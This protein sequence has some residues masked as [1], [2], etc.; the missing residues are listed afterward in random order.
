[1]IYEKHNTREKFAVIDH[2]NDGTTLQRV[3]KVS[4][5][6]RSALRQQA[7]LGKATSEQKGA[8]GGRRHHMTAVVINGHRCSE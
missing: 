7:Y 8:V 6:D 4:P 1:M 5:D 2:D 3:T